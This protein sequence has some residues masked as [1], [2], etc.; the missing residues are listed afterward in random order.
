[1]VNEP[2]N[3][4]S[5]TAQNTDREL[6]REREGDYYA[7]S[8]HVTIDGKIGIQHA[9]TRGIMP[10]GEWFKAGMPK[11]SNTVAADPIAENAF[12]REWLC[13]LF[14]ADEVRLALK[15]WRHGKDDKH[16]AGKAKGEEGEA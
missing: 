15:V 7:D 11:P 12:M 8:I 1:M 6:W 16:L 4:V 10:V 3:L 2:T 13:N 9:G 14:G 5:G